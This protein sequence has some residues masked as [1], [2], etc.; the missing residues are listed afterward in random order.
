MNYQLNL[1]LVFNR[2]YSDEDDENDS[3][4]SDNAGSRIYNFNNY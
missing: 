4:L 3:P 2:P 1:F